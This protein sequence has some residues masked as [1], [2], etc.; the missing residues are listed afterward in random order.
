MQF[1]HPYQVRDASAQ[2]AYCN[3]A[4]R[5]EKE[6]EYITAHLLHKMCDAEYLWFSFLNEF[7]QLSLSINVQSQVKGANAPPCR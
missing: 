3:T 5:G 1:D 4:A 6:E 2:A 7:L